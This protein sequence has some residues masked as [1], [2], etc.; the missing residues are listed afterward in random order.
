MVNP[1]DYK[2]TPHI[3]Y[4][5]LK[6]NKKKTAG[7]LEGGEKDEGEKIGRL[8][9]GIKAGLRV[10]EFGRGNVKGGKNNEGWKVESWD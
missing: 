2:L 3:L 5:L 9:G 1:V 4:F 8:E 10:P 6:P 7:R